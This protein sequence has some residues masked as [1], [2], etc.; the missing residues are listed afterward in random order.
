MPGNPNRSGR[1]EAPSVRA[2]RFTVNYL[3]LADYLAIAAEVTGLDPD[4]LS[5][6]TNL[7]LADSA[8]PKGGMEGE[9][10]YADFIDKAAVLVVRLAKN[11]PLPDGNKRATWVARRLFIESSTWAWRTYPSVDEAEEAVVAIASSEW[12]EKRVAAWLTSRLDLASGSGA[13]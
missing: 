9:D 2:G 8:I 10:F 7:D 4:I 5:R 13:S 12:D 1:A 6:V 11:H 3:G